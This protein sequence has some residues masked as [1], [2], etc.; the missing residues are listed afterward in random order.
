MTFHSLY[1][2]VSHPQMVF[3]VGRI[4]FVQKFFVNSRNNYLLRNASLKSQYIPHRR[5]IVTNVDWETVGSKK[6]TSFRK[7][8][9][10][11]L[12][13]LMPAISFSLGFW[14]IKRLK[15]KTDLIAE[16]E[17][18]LA[19]PPLILP[20]NLNNEAAMEMQYR[21]VL[22]KGRFLHEKEIL[23]GPRTYEGEIGYAVITPFQRENGSRILVNR[24]WIRKSMANQ[25]KRNPNGLPKETVV[26]EGLIKK[27]AGRNYFTPDNDPLKGIY[28]YVDIPQI[29]ETSQSEPMIIEEIFDPNE[30][31]M[32]WEEFAMEGIPIGRLPRLDIRNNHAQYIATWFGVGIAS[33]I[34]FILLF[35]RPTS[36]KTR[37]VKQLSKF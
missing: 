19:L 13:V 5:T 6:D 23:V 34:M 14:Q 27:P 4:C 35:R 24:G 25:T 30:S 16:Y 28:F 17:N 10:L 36:D 18:R 15:W 37:K 22:A 33:S 26:I 31:F 20:A 1:H 9:V 8:V 3:R 32:S 7:K 12:L 29:A 2:E 11:S 21:R